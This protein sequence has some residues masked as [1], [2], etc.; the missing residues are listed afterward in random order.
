MA[1][2]WQNPT[3][4]M[5]KSCRWV[6]LFGFFGKYSFLVVHE[7]GK[8]Y[9]ILCLF[10][11]LWC[12]RCCPLY[13][14]AWAKKAGTSGTL[15]SRGWT[16]ITASQDLLIWQKLFAHRRY[17]GRLEKGLEV[18][19][20]WT[21]LSYSLVVFLEQVISR[22]KQSCRNDFE[23]ASGTSLWLICIPN[24]DSVISFGTFSSLQVKVETR[25]EGRV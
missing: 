12:A 15:K 24:M 16:W 14:V 20:V 13:E 18:A 19:G 11:C 23:E 3:K 25:L 17:C 7:K 4:S 10:L 1:W 6:K 22:Y 5:C 2:S 8:V 21:S 9:L